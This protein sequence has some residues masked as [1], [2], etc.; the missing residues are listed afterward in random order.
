MFQIYSIKVFPSTFIK[1]FWK[2]NL[3]NIFQL[4][5]EFFLIKKNW[6]KNLKNWKINHNI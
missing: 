2:K 1:I 3:E 6:K 4:L 5:I